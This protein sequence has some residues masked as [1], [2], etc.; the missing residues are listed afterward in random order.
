[1]NGS[2]IPSGTNT[3]GDWLDEITES[4]PILKFVLEVGKKAVAKPE[5]KTNYC[6]A[7]YYTMVEE[8]QARA[9]ELRKNSTR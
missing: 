9:I 7:F 3:R 6:R 8:A 4:D 1:M 2:N 5:W